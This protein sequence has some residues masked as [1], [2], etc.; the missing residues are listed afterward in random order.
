MLN[1]LQA[2]YPQVCLVQVN[3]PVQDA[4]GQPLPGWDTAM[5]PIRCRLSPVSALESKRQEMT[6][7]VG[8]HVIALAGHYG[9][10]TTDM[11]AVVDGQAYDILG[12]DH[13]GQAHT[14]RLRV[15]VVSV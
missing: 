10:I 15:Q 3:T 11:R 5:S 2:F 4:A 14:T 13:D 9:G 1:R 12:V 8:T 6:V 7:T